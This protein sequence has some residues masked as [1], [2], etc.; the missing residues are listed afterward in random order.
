MTKTIRLTKQ[1]GKL[2]SIKLLQ[3]KD[4][5]KTQ[6]HIEATYAALPRKRLIPQLEIETI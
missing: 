6:I 1:K 5:Q 4:P 3:R 2:D